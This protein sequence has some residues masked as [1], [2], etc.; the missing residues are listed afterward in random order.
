MTNNSHS[1]PVYIPR[2]PCCGYNYSGEILVQFGLRFEIQPTGVLVYSAATDVLYALTPV[3]S[4]V[5]CEIARYRGRPVSKQALYDSLYPK[6]VP[7]PKIID[8]HVSKLRSKM[9]VTLMPAEIVTVWGRGYRLE[10]RKQQEKVV[11]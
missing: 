8:V 3:E 10:H 9:R 7:E 11:A 1:E 4:A 6:A 5:L 2:C